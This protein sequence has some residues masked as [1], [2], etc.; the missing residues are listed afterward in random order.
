MTDALDTHRLREA[1]APLNAEVAYAVKACSN[2][3]ILNLMD[4]NGA[5][6]D[7][8]VYKRQVESLSLKNSLH[9]PNSLKAAEILVRE[10]FTVLPYINAD[11]VLAKRLQ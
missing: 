3:A 1:L 4:R 5:G 2:I 11:P 6:F 10:G 9:H 7:I 8:D